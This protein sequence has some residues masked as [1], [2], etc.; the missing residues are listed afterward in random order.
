M[1]YL[2]FSSNLILLFKNLKV[3]ENQ[4]LLTIHDLTL[5]NI[6]KLSRYDYK[7]CERMIN[8]LDMLQ[9]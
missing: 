8:Y 2:Q 1:I 7:S 3:Q 9:K 5:H 6:V 4:K